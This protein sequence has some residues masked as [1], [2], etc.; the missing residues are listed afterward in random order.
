VAS[1]RRRS[2]RKLNNYVNRIDRD[3]RNMAKRQSVTRLGDRT[4]GTP[5]LAE[6]AVT[7][8]ILDETVATDISDANAAAAAAA[9][10]AATALSTADGKNTIYR[11]TSQ[12]TGGTY[13]NGDLWF[14][15]DDDNKLYRY[16]S[17]PSPAWTSFTLGNNA[18]SN[19]SANKITAGTLDASL[20]TVSNLNAGSITAGTLTGISIAGG[21]ID[22]G[23]A[24]TTSFHVDTLGNVWIGG[25]TYNVAPFKISSD[26]FVTS[27]NGATFLGTLSSSSDARFDG[28]A[29]VFSYIQNDG[30]FQSVTG[31]TVSAQMGQ[32]EMFILES[33]NRFTRMNRLG[34]QTSVSQFDFFTNL[35]STKYNVGF[36]LRESGSRIYA[37]VNDLASTLTFWF[38]GAYTPNFTSDRRLKSNVRSVSRQ[39]LDKFY[40]IPVHEWEWNENADKVP[41]LNFSKDNPT[42]IGVI[43]DEIKQIYPYV[44]VDDDEEEST[45]ATIAYG[46]LAPQMLCAILDMNTRITE[47]EDRLSE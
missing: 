44:V 19:L 42:S 17:S 21:K 36:N 27:T 1:N 11:Q 14:D 9:A 20:I 32:T 38:P 30:R 18:L 6:G 25:A 46:W 15:S 2:L 29:G 47:L 13:A 39:S 7:S 45:F 12:P 8:D 24:D 3:V 28:G 26:G 5:Q 35:Q 37:C 33:A 10:D 31:A 22:I 34:T 23:G 41:M 4:V 40:S 43:A 16:S